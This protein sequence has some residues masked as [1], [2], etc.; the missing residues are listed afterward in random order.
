MINTLK[1]VKNPFKP[2]NH[3]QVFFDNIVHKGNWKKQMS[4]K[5]ESKVIELLENFGYVLEKDFYR[6][7]P[8]EPFVIDIAFPKIHLAIEVD[9]SSHD[10]KIQIAKD[11]VRDIYLKENGWFVLR[12][13]EKK[14]FEDKNPFYKYLL[15]ECIEDLTKDYEDGKIYYEDFKNYFEQ[16]YE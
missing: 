2:N 10:S 6:Q 4:G 8:I 15:K 7:Y 3:R 14:L 1:K 12:L 16:D 13:P 5:N 9:G 11:K